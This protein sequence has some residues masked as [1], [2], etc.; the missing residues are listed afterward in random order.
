MVVIACLILAYNF[1]KSLEILLI[2]SSTLPGSSCLSDCGLKLNASPS[3][4]RFIFLHVDANQS[5]DAESVS[6]T[7]GWSVA[8]LSGSSVTLACVASLENSSISFISRRV[9]SE[10][11]GSNVFVFVIRLNSCQFSSG[12]TSLKSALSIFAFSSANGGGGAGAA[13]HVISTANKHADSN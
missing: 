8:V 10:S 2:M 4:F 12:P 6:V 7:S 13:R 5:D 3:S 1:F 11:E 9:F